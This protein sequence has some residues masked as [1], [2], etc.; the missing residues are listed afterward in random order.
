MHARSPE[1]GGTDDVGSVGGSDDEHVLLGALAV[2][3]SQNQNLTN[4]K[5]ESLGVSAGFSSRRIR[6]VQIE[7]KGRG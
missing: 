3:L 1:D 6:L 2:H 7:N 5:P 4:E